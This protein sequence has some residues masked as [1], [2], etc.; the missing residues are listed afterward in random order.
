M[1]LQT[2]STSSR[3]PSPH[4]PSSA[5]WYG[6]PEA[7]IILPEEDYD[8]RPSSSR[9]FLSKTPAQGSSIEVQTHSNE[10]MIWVQLPGFSWDGI[11]LATQKRRVLHIV[12][13]KWDNNGGEDYNPFCYR[14]LAFSASRHERYRDVIFSSYS[15]VFTTVRLS[16]LSGHFE[17][18][19][20]FGYDADLCSVRAEF[21]NDWL[22]V[23]VPRRLIPISIH[24]Q[25]S[26]Y[27]P[28]GRSS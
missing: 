12:A 21:K 22:R 20:A 16:F 5:E 19:V 7:P 1:T 4:S 10:Y 14:L 13:D 25:S 3:C 23:S 6:G 2:G 18:R 9:A 8:G 24:P 28:I 15:S 11:T 17:R 26:R 27:A